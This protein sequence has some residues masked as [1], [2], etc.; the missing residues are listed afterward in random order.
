MRKNVVTTDNTASDVWADTAYCSQAN[1]AWL[2]RHGR[3]SSI[4]RNKPRG[5]PMPER[6]TKANAA[7]SSVQARVE[8]VFTRQKDQRTSSSAPSESPVPPPR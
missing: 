8:H 2:E 6:T 5:R 3:V 7:K 4:H 1:E